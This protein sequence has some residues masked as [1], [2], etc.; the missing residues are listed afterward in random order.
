M[1][2]GVTDACPLCIWRAPYPS[3]CAPS[4]FWLC[5]A[6]CLC[7]YVSLSLS[8]PPLLC[9]NFWF[10]QEL[11]GWLG[12]DLSPSPFLGSAAPTHL[13]PPPMARPPTHAPKFLRSQVWGRG[14]RKPG[15]QLL[16][17]EKPPFQSLPPLPT[18]TQFKNTKLGLVALS[19]ASLPAQPLP[20]PLLA[21]F[22]FPH[23]NTKRPPT[24]RP[25][26]FRAGQPHPKS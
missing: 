24:F 19:A 9:W 26:H 21:Y 10:C 8:L 22:P 20:G 23:P 13:W 18:H 25:F 15:S 2:D 1:T 3:V 14:D 4:S 5:V 16:L 12:S 7:M 11:W 17:Q 6:L